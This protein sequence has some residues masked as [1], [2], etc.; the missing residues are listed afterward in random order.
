MEAFVE[1]LWSDVD[2]MVNNVN[3]AATKDRMPLTRWK[4][5]THREFGVFLGMIIGAVAFVESG[6]QLWKPKFPGIG[7]HPRYDKY[8]SETRFKEIR[9]YASY[10]MLSTT[11]AAA[12]DPWARVRGA[13]DGFNERRRDIFRMPCIIIMDETMSA[14]APQSSK[15]GGLPHLSFIIRK[16]EPLGTE[17]KTTADGATGCMTAMEIQEGRDRMRDK[18]HRDGHTK[19]TTACIMRL[20]DEI[21]AAP[22]GYKRLFLGDSWFASVDTAVAVGKGGVG[23]SADGDGVD[24]FGESGGVDQSGDA[25]DATS[26]DHFIGIVKT[27][28]ARYP[29]KYIRNAVDGMPGGVKIVLTAEVDGVDLVACGWKYNRKTVLAFILTKGAGSTAYD[30][31]NPYYARFQDTFG[32]TTERPVPRPHALGVYFK[33]SNV[34]DVHNQFRQGELALEKRWQTQDS[35]FRLFT[36]LVGIVTVDAYKALQALM[37]TRSNKRGMGIKPFA[38]LLALQLVNNRWTDGSAVGGG[39]NVFPRRSSAASTAA[40]RHVAGMA[41]DSGNSSAALSTLSA[42][43]PCALILHDQFTEVKEGKQ[44]GR[45][46]R[47]QKACRMCTIRKC[48]SPNRKPHKTSW[49]CSGPG[50]VGMGFCHASSGRDCFAVHLEIMA[51]AVGTSAPTTR[52]S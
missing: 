48:P 9:K 11:A 33:H 1:L 52:T 2:A 28:H 5:V 32:N 24:T 22:T 38:S 19:Q 10:A 16:P 40:S 46:T 12:G 45:V 14:W 44:K 4:Q 42:E 3:I 23:G 25:I 6:K 30:D 34:V 8:M 21:A 50:C 51:K 49:V 41:G 43:E 47:L 29:L 7:G 26:G 20:R 39:R 35:W 31:T 37:N 17:F 13:I 15:T 18:A 27:S 36:T